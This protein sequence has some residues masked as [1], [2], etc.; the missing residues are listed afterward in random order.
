[1]TKTKIIFCT[2]SYML[3][4]NSYLIELIQAVLVRNNIPAEA[5]NI[6]QNED[7]TTL[8]PN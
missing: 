4:I 2:D 7:M 5:W 6:S 8:R 3:S 1:M